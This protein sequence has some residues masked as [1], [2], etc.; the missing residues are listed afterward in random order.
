MKKETFFVSRGEI[1][2]LL[3]V[4]SAGL[5][6][7]GVLAGSFL[8]QKQTEFR[9]KAQNPQTVEGDCAG[10]NAWV[11]EWP[12][13]SWKNCLGVGLDKQGLFNNTYC[14][15]EK[16]WRHQAAQ[17]H[18]GN[19]SEC[20][21]VQQDLKTTGCGQNTPTPVTNNNTFN[22]VSFENSA[23]RCFH[24]GVDI[25]PEAQADKSIKFSTWVKIF[26]D[27][28]DGHIQLFKDGVWLRMN[29]WNKNTNPFVYS[30]EWTASPVVGANSSINVNYLVKIDECNDLGN[31]DSINCSLVVDGDGKP[32]NVQCGREVNVAPTNPPNLTPGPSGNIDGYCLGEGGASK[33]ANAFCL[34]W[35]QSSPYGGGGK[36][37]GPHYCCDECDP[38]QE[39]VW[40]NTCF[41]PNSQS[42]NYRG[43]CNSDAG[44]AFP[45]RCFKDPNDNK[46]KWIS[47]N[48]YGECNVVCAVGDSQPIP[49][50]T[51]TPRTGGPVNS[52]T[53]VLATSTPVPPGY[54][55]NTPTATPIPTSL[56]SPT[57]TPT[58]A[59][60]V[61]IYQSSFQPGVLRINPNVTV[62]WRNLETTSHSV[63]ASSSSTGI[64]FDSGNIPYNETFRFTFTTPGNYYY[65]SKMNLKM[66]GIIIVEDP[67]VSPTPSLRPSETTYTPSPTFIPPVVTIIPSPTPNVLP[68]CYQ[69]E[70]NGS[71]DGYENIVILGDKYDS[72]QALINDAKKVVAN[73]KNTNLGA[74]RLGRL[75]YY[76]N[77]T[78]SD[79]SVNKDLLYNYVQAFIEKMKCNGTT[80]LLLTNRFNGDETTGLA[81]L[82]HFLILPG[83]VRGSKEAI[84]VTKWLFVDRHEL[85]HAIAGIHDEY[86]FNRDTQI[87]DLQKDTPSY[88]CSKESVVQPNSRCTDWKNKYEDTGCYNVCGFRNWYRSTLDSIMSNTK[89]GYAEYN[90]PSLDLWSRALGL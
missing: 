52:P 84:V 30:P 13:K 74:A 65:Y 68:Q 51:P 2:S 58:P 17:A 77:T 80:S 63:S 19:G 89:Q 16:M 57:P 59:S 31:T 62:E 22:K 46:W 34:Q 33:V 8:A 18:G 90:K 48:H 81:G 14:D 88:N 12:D 56:Y 28:K 27:G 66:I 49:T 44:V 3:T 35:G 85:A 55:T 86:D 5:M 38:G 50:P 37:V 32:S 42:S 6:L 73:V 53:P 20:G 11:C 26:S 67:N 25:Q 61:Y 54:P 23:T 78:L 7:L 79:F 47:Q 75:N 40:T 87:T 1:A 72:V 64:L 39:G 76:V 60:D 15:G 4:F 24:L 29:G 70:V 82:S 10:S 45:L 43:P 69:I 71:G 83:E 36:A 9:S 41:R 21:G